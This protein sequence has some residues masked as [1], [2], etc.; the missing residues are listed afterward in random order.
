MNSKVID[1][2]RILTDYDSET[3]EEVVL[4]EV[5]HDEAPSYNVKKRDLLQES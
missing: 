1:S 4:Q 3:G 5:M 2:N